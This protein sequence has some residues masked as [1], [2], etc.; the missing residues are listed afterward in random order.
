M[1]TLLKRFLACNGG[2]SSTD[3]V[4]GLALLSLPVVVI[5]CKLGH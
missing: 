5:L 3:M 4:L 1:N 2:A